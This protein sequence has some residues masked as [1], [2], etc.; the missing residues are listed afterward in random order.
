MCDW[1][2]GALA[3][4]VAPSGRWVAPGYPDERGPSSG[5]VNTVSALEVC[6]DNGGLYLC[7]VDWPGEAFEAKH[8]RKIDDHVPDEEDAE[9]IRLING[10]PVEEPV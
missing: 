3:L 10:A 8:F 1:H 4:C 9:T 7:F 5:S 6:P 2:A